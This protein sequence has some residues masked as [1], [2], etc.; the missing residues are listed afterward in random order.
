MDSPDLQS[1]LDHAE[2]IAVVGIS[3][4]PTRPSHNIARYLREA[5]YRILPINPSYE[6][7]YD[8]PCYASLE[9]VPD[10]ERIDIVNI[11]RSPRHTEGIVEAAVARAERTGHRAAIWTQLGVSSAEAERRAAA[12][13]L[14]Y[15]RN[16]CILVEHARGQQ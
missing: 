2:T 6:R 1:L 13:G 15:V 10:D 16:R 7:W 5:G 11:F 3:L 8:L 12:A 4:R 9:D 14:P